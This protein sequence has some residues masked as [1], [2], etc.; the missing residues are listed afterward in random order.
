MSK[1]ETLGPN[2]MKC[3]IAGL[4]KEAA[5][6]E[7]AK[8]TGWTKLLDAAS[9][10][11]DAATEIRHLETI[12]ADILAMPEIQSIPYG[13]SEALDRARERTLEIWYPDRPE[14]SGPAFR[15]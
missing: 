9:C 8:E 5:R 10:I 13:A 6:R 12:M 2:V 7:D 4:H 11:T 15:R 1:P 14:I 3:I